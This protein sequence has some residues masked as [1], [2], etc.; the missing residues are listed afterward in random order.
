MCEGC[1]CLRQEVYIG[2]P[3]GDFKAT[4]LPVSALESSYNHLEYCVMQG[5]AIC[6]GWI[7]PIHS[8]FQ[9]FKVKY[10]VT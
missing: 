10:Y 8:Y 7:L 5:H 2:F 1:F 6:W 3:L 9:V 4:C